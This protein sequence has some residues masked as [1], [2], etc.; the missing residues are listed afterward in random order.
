MNP[1]LIARNLRTEYLKLLRTAFHPRQEDLAEAF[2]SE[3]EKDG[4]LTREPFIALA[5][6]YKIAPP[7]T[8]L[9]PETQQ[10]FGAI[11]QTPYQHQ[12]EAC[13]RIIAG[14]PT[15]AATG[16]GS[17]K[18]EAFLMPILDHCF[19]VHQL[20]RPSVKALLIY[21]MNA[22]ANDQ[23]DRIR[24][25][26]AGTDISFGRYTR[27]TKMIGTR[28]GDAPSNERILRT[29]FRSQPPDL[30][31]TNYMMLEYMLMRGDGR[32]IFRNHQ[33]RFIVLDEMHTYHGLLG[34]DVACLLRRLREALRR[35][36]PAFDPVFVGTSATL[37]A[38]EEGD[39]KLGIA[40]F[41]SRLTGQDTSPEAVI[42]ETADTPRL[43]EG[44]QLP[45]APAITEEELAN[46]NAS[47]SQKAA[48]LLRKLTGA[49]ADNPASLRR[50]WEGSALPYLLMDWL[51]QPQ[52]EEE[53]VRRLRERQ[54]RAGVPADTLRREI[55][56]ALLV[57]P[58]I[59]DESPVKLRP[60]V[61]RMLRGLAR[62]W[63]CTNPQC[64]K[65]LGEEVEECDLCGCRA[66][67]LALC[68]TC[69]W[70]FFMAAEGNPGLQPWRPR[71]SSP[72]T[73]FVF[74]PVHER[75]DIETE[76][77]ESGAEEDIPQK[78]IPQM[79]DADNESTF[80]KEEAPDAYLDPK[81]LQLGN[82]P[83]DLSSGDGHSP[84]PVRLYQGRGTRCPVCN[85]RYGRFDV[86]T[87][88]SLGNSSALAHV[89]RVLMR[90]L[91]TNQQKLLV[92]CDSRQ[93]AAHQARFIK[94]IEEHLRM[95]RFTY[96]ALKDES[97]RHDFE[98]LVD[99][100]YERY[101]KEGI[102]FRS[103]KKDQQK[104]DKAVIQGELLTEFAIAPRVRAGLERLGLVRVRYAG[105]EE[106]LASACFQTLCAEHLLA[107]KLSGYSIL[108]LLDEI[109]QR[110]ALN[111]ELLTSR[112]YPGDKLSREYRIQ[113]NRYVGVPAAF[114]PPGQKATARK[115]FRLLTTWN[116][117]GAPTNIQQLWRQF[118]GDKVTADSL[119]AVL[120]WLQER[121]Y[122]AWGSIGSEEESG[123]GWQVALDTL[124]FEVGRSFCH[125]SRCDKM[126]SNL[127]P[128]LP[129]FRPR[130]PGTLKEWQGPVQ[131]GNLN[132]LM[133]V[134][135]YAPTLFPAEHSA[136]VPDSQREE[137]EEGFM[138]KVPPRPN[139][140]ACTPTLEMGVNIGDLEA[141][142]MRNI[143]PSPANYAQRSGRT[144]RLS[145]MGIVAGFSRNTPHDGYFFDHPDEIIAGA[146]PPP[147][148]NLHNREAIARHVRSL[149]LEHAELDL[150]S[151]LE[152]YLSEKGQLNEPQVKALVDKVAQ[153]G[154][155]ALAVAQKLWSDIPGVTMAFLQAI[156]Q[157]FPAG[158][159]AA[160]EDRGHLLAEAAEEVRKLGE[161]IELTLREKQAQDGFR[162]LA[163]RLRKDNKYAYLPR[164]LAE[165]G[166]LPGFAFPSDPGSVSLGY[167]PEVVFSGRLQA[168]RE[169]APGQIIYA[170]GGRWR[171][172][173]VAMH[174]PG[175]NRPSGQL[176]FSFT[177]CGSCGL[178]N[179]PDR[180]FC[181]RC[182]APIGDDQGAGLRTFT[183]WDAGAF[184]SWEAEV[185]AD[186]EEERQVKAYDIRPHPQ[187]DTDG[188]RFQV[189]SWALE[190]RSQ[191]EIWF[192]N[193]GAKD[194]TALGEA[195]GQSPGF[196]LCRVCGHYFSEVERQ[197]IADGLANDEAEPR[198]GRSYLGGHE[199]RCN[200]K[201]EPLSLGHQMKADSLR[202]IVPNLGQQDVEGV[203]WAWSFLYAMI[204]GA[205]RLFEIDED[206]LEAFVLTKTVSDAEN[207]THEE[208]LDM[209]WIDRI[210]GGSGILQRLAQHFPQV[211]AAALKHLEGHSCPNS[212]YRCL[213][214]YRNQWLHKFLDWRLVFPFLRALTAE[215]VIGAGTIQGNQPVSSTAG[216]D[217]EEAR[218]AGCE[219]PQEHRLLKAI[220]SD[221]ML[222]EPHK[223]YEVFDKN[224]LLTRADFAYLDC[225]PKLLIY[226]DGLAWHTSAK[227]RTHDNR[228]SNRL[229]MMGYVVLRFLGTEVHNSLDT[230][231]AQIK[232]ARAV[233]TR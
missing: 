100:L 61:H 172:T 69:G 129:C 63:R 231:I 22:L 33:V 233:T 19:R 219:S 5:Q 35:A 176:T 71:V 200:G 181:S 166:L 49:T 54:E 50:L 170:R 1:L 9:L 24:K 153:A 70:D 140:L 96:E 186:S 213:R 228:I 72:K 152:K 141:V 106:D 13:K 42:T 103:K 117:R 74:D 138:D 182:Q 67:P 114:I 190:L 215:K 10:R 92:F 98:W 198:D 12:A 199:K 44:V 211:A 93:D 124:E 142:A 41:F 180:D 6:P 171:V 128:G 116:T 173:G 158:I 223:Q 203:R 184:Q 197:Q 169:F 130:C 205:I 201:A 66:L 177:L 36:N 122:L 65:L 143:P 145:R 149:I 212:C 155:P 91:P 29:E 62:F 127:P 146:I 23:R 7:L 45:P 46:F 139:L 60:R 202:V 120:N 216:P 97:E 163:V 83:D 109:R 156:A 160:L 157:G 195:K 125:C 188:V 193:H 113:V 175:S 222:P 208:V 14:Q 58:C 206:D 121:E 123:E 73:V 196:H 51:R 79:D 164:V 80:E 11:S 150:P 226:V 232:E 26:L 118:H 107:P 21:P 27:E 187:L 20:G 47:D 101:I 183:A 2:N 40:R 192:I 3:I 221:G 90:D 204:Q 75:M 112:L 179:K 136:A 132:A 17:G 34:T 25:L 159:R 224:H 119:E 168:Q 154:A 31:L 137:A 57:G 108:V 174:R 217:W 144:G 81:T 178:A 229:Q 134:E 105:I 59:A 87:P 162:D 88:V 56:A 167:D 194:A 104:R 148:F 135:A 48:A 214:S 218:A 64:G 133:A 38:G 131:E 220:E 4:F 30:L 15:I 227:Q 43:P 37:Q 161:K 115:S 85:S 84:R 209:L 225:D 230:C 52:S 111:H 16:T 95:R 53:I 147:K 68:R 55:E 185:A 151:N 18:T 32:E 86:L 165:A 189:G 99:E 39:P 102:F 89:S 78:D 191:E 76:E 126:A 110:M 77:D 82:R 8:E 210:T 94:G 207:K 28:P